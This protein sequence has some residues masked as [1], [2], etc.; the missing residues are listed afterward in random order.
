MKKICAIIT[1]VIWTFSRSFLSY[2]ISDC[3]LVDKILAD[4]LKSNQFSDNKSEVDIQNYYNIIKEMVMYQNNHEWLAWSSIWCEEWNEIYNYMLSDENYIKEGEGITS[5]DSAFL[6]SVEE[7]NKEEAESYI[8]SRIDLEKYDNVKLFFAGIEYSTSK[9]SRYIYNGINY[10]FVY[11][12]YEGNKIVVLKNTEVPLEYLSNKIKN[13]D[14]TT[15]YS[16]G[17]ISGCDRE[18]IQTALEVRTARLNGYVTDSDMSIIDTISNDVDNTLKFYTNTYADEIAT[19]MRP[20]YTY[21]TPYNGKIPAKVKVGLIGEK[22]QQIVHGATTVMTVS[23]MDY[24]KNTV[25]HELGPAWVADHPEFKN[26][27]EGY[28]AQL[29]ITKQY[30]LW[31]T[32]Y[33]YEYPDAGVDLYDIPDKDQ[34][35]VIDSY[36]NLSE[37]YKK[38]VDDAIDEFYKRYIL[39]RKYGSLFCTHYKSTEDKAKEFG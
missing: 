19:S 5:I 21:T 20:G 34:T 39:C 13:T 11:I 24:I 15:S 8:K 2:G 4:E 29:V 7:V 25:I 38:V 3:F 23:F 30:A 22:N 36:N 14:N 27:P 18:A 37:R 26:R 31:F 1:I 10:R 17:V 28:G 6:V 35:F 12:G 33:Q 16:L 32:L 9:A